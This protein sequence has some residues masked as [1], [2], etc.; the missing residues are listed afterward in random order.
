MKTFLVTCAA[1]VLMCGMHAAQAHQ[2]LRLPPNKG[3]HLYLVT[4]LPN[5]SSEVVR[6][7]L[8]NAIPAQSPDLV[9]SGVGLPIAVA[10]DGT[11]Y[12]SEPLVSS[13]GQ[14][15]IDA[16]PPGSPT[17][18]RRI[19]LPATNDGT[20]ATALTVDASGYLYAGY[21]SFISGI[22]I[23]APPNAS[24]SG[25]PTHGIAVYAPNANGNAPPLLAFR[26]AGLQGGPQ[27]LAFDAQE[28][29]HAANYFFHRGQGQGVILN[30]AD[31]RSAPRLVSRID[32]G[33]GLIPRGMEC[34]DDAQNIYVQVSGTGSSPPVTVL[35]F[36]RQAFGPAKPSRTLQVANN[37]GDDLAIAGPYLYTSLFRSPSSELLGYVKHASGSPPPKFVR[38]YQNMFPEGLAIGP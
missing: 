4:G 24:A 9:Y 3:L 12:A 1:L 30:I 8:V 34:S 15:V 19:T 29:L 20:S 23:P 7:P 21:A 33:S 28:H 16:F 38:T 22:R 35:T 32:L 26:F 37:A 14:Q 36:P 31:P 10:R 11:F 5:G 17:P 25:L 13:F 2:F 27:A 6:Y 18:A